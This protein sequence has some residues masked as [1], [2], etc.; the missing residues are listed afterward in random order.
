MQLDSPLLLQGCVPGRVHGAVVISQI[1]ATLKSPQ[2]RL[3]T[4]CVQ[5]AHIRLLQ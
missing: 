3:R 4:V 1:L 5:K 2:V